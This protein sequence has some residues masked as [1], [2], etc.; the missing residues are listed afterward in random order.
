MMAALDNRRP[1]PEQKVQQRQSVARYLNLGVISRGAYGVVH[2]AWD[3]KSGEIVAMKEE[4]HGMSQSTMREISI[5]K[6]LPRHPSIV[7]LKGVEVDKR[8]RVF[9]V[10]ECL[11]KD[12]KKWMEGRRLQPYSVGE[13]KSVMRQILE[14]VCFL[15]KHGVMHRDL[16]PSNI[17][18]DTKAAPQIKLCDF[19]LSKQPARE[20]GAHT[21]GVVTLWYRAPEVL[22]GATAYWSAVDMWSVGCIMA[23]LVLGHVLFPGVSEIHQLVCIRQVMGAPHLLRHRLT[24]V[25]SVDGAP[26]LSA[27]GF[28][29]LLTLLTCNPHRR[30]TAEQALNHAWFAH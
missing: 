23:E 27:S 11:E 7:E 5:L 12:L 2:R 1:F 10:M 3:L 26:L 14:G 13:V 20:S 30:I 29:L 9:V 24:A 28:D 21:P 17:L 6:S 16:K 15:H 25:A 4:F 18:V 22:M 8:R 19:G